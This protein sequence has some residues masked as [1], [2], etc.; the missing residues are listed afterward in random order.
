MI[1]RERANSFLRIVYTD[2]LVEA[3]TVLASKANDGDQVSRKL[4]NVIG[5]LE[6]MPET[7]APVGY[8]KDSYRPN[9]L[10]SPLRCVLQLR[11]RNLLVTRLVQDIVTNRLPVEVAIQTLS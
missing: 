10:V 6:Q 2:G 9:E 4:L 5:L 7:S 1:P 3:K 11:E 8:K